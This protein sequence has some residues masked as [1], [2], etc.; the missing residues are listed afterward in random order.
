MTIFIYIIG[1][2]EVNV[3]GLSGRERLQRML[4]ANNGEIALV[5]DLGS[6]P[7]GGQVLFL[8]AD[9]L[10]DARVLA[11]LIK[12]QSNLVLNSNNDQIVAIRI[13]DGNVSNVLADFLGEGNGDTISTFPNYSLDDLNLEFQQKNL[14]RRMHLMY[15]L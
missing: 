12:T 4:K 7:D 6:I 3:W 11:A 14:K 1:N 13:A 5:D 9:H 2:S 15:Y 8:C 10:F